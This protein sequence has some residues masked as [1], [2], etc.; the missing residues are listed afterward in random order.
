MLLWWGP[1]LTQLYNDAFRPLIG[2]KHP[3]SIGQDAADCYPEAWPELGPLAESALAGGGA[4]FSRN[5]YLPY[6]RHGYVEEAATS[7]CPTS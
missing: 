5:L 1:W 2:E 6:E 7:S 4:T 3:R